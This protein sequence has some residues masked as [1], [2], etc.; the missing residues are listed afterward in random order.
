MLVGGS[1]ATPDWNVNNS[2]APGYIANRPFYEEKSNDKQVVLQKSVSASEFNNNQVSLSSDNYFAEGDIV[3]VNINGTDFNDLTA[4]Y[5]G[6]F[7]CPVVKGKLTDDNEFTI[8]SPDSYGTYLILNKAI[9]VAIEISVVGV[10]TVHK[11]DNKFIDVAK[12]SNSIGIIGK[13]GAGR[14][15][16][17]FNEAR[18]ASGVCSHA[19]GSATI[20]SGSYSHAEGSGTTASGDYSHAEGYYTRAKGLYQHVEGRVNIPDGSNKYIH[21]AGNGYDGDG[22]SDDRSESNA[23]TLDWS[24]NGWYSGNIT[25]GKN[26]VIGVGTDDEVTLTPAQLKQLLTLLNN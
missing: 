16:E 24:G 2:S 23:Y 12:L 11:L 1:S 18:A 15:S 26:L 4:T 14:N 13:Q 6:A 10:I 17:I 22:N 25:A 8:A 21:I 9:D 3:S 19:E 20:A 5:D 7:S